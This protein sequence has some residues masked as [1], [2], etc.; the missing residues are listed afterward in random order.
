MCVCA[1]AECVG[2]V[3]E[4]KARPSSSERHEMADDHLVRFF[5]EHLFPSPSS[6]YILFTFFPFSFYA[7]LVRSVL[8]DTGAVLLGCTRAL[9]LGFPRFY[10][11]LPGFTGM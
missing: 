4:W 5:F 7:G 6:F 10:W 8:L 11:S 1:C 9:L 2:C 3:V